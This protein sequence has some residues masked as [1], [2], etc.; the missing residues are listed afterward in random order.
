MSRY[1]KSILALVGALL[2]WGTAAL[3]DNTVELRE[4]W[5][6]LAAVATAF[7]VYQVPND[8]PQGAEPDPDMSERGD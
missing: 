3:W 6:L 1:R 4:W 5:S 8:P 7:G 2:T